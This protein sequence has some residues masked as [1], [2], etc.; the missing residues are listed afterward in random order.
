MAAL[1]QSVA[2]YKASAATSTAQMARQG[3][4][5]NGLFELVEKLASAPSADPI[6]LTGAKKV[7]FDR[8]QKKEDKMQVM[9]DAIASLKKK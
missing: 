6:T 8:L 3:E 7:K 9:A 4:V 2:A 5:I 1:D